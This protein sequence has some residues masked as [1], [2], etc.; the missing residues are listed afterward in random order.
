[1]EL[2][3]FRDDCVK[4]TRSVI[5]RISLAD[6]RLVIPGATRSARVK[7]ALDQGATR[8]LAGGAFAAAGTAGAVSAGWIAP[9]AISGIV[10]APIG[11]AVLGVIAVAGIWKLYANREE[12]LRSEQ[13]NRA[14]SI[15]QAARST[16]E[17]A[18][19]EV[20]IALD[21]V[22]EGFRSA[23][24]SRLAPLRHD[25]ERIR[26]MC[27]LQKQLARRIALDAQ[28]RLDQWRDTLGNAQHR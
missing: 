27:L 18:F 10:A 5:P 9:A 11:A 26:E 25:A 20:T 28:R 17:K 6:W 4:N 3:E 24:L 21:D 16:V 14:E 15:R 7:D 1:M 2:S 8:T 12:R 19:A 22:A 13:R 23:S